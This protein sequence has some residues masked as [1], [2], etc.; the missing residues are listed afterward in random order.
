MDGVWRNYNGNQRVV[1][2]RALSL[3]EIAEVLDT[4]PGWMREQLGSRLEDVDGRR[5]MNIEDLVNPAPELRPRFENDHN[6]EK[7]NG[8]E[9]TNH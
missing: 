2:Y 7:I 3:V 6:G 4:M 8:D 9:R 1:S 5:V